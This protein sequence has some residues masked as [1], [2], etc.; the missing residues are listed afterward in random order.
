MNK[1]RFFLITVLALGLL[2]TIVIAQQVGET[3]TITQPQSSDQYLAGRFVQVTAPIDGDLVI[4]GQELVVDAQISGDVIAAGQTLDL[5]DLVSDD[6]RAAG[7]TLTL[8][9]QI[10]GHVVA[11]GREVVLGS[12]AS[13]ED[14]AWFAGQS[15]VVDGRVG[16]ELR[17]AG[18]TVVVSG[19]IGGDAIIAAEEIEV[20]PGAIIRGDLIWDSEEEPQIAA[21]ATVEGEIIEEDLTDAFEEMGRFGDAGGVM[22]AVFFVITLLASVLAVFLVFPRFSESVAGRIRSTPLRTVGLGIG[23]LVGTPILVVLLF[24]SS[25]GWIIALAILFGFFVLLICAMLF[26]MVSVGKLG[27]ELTKKAEASRRPMVLLAIGLGVV[28]ILLLAQ[29]PVLGPIIVLL[30]LLGGL[31]AISGEFLQ[32]YRQPA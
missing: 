22:G 16:E 19:E 3:V 2:T 20:G 11:A 5:S 6:V 29:V 10:M 8:D 28:L 13:V 17:A 27:L 32:R 1:K 15:L 21:T 7:Q 26:G 12:T 25:I 9:A 24:I 4:V 31:G 14:W 18:Q 30:V 23:M